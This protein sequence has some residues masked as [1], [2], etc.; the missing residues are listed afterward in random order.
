MPTFFAATLPRLKS[1]RETKIC[2]HDVDPGAEPRTVALLDPTGKIRSH[3]ARGHGTRHHHWRIQ[4][5]MQGTE[6]RIIPE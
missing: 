1:V 2:G 6:Y 3:A 4:P 5:C